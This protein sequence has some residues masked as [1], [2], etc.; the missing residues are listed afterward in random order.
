MI[1]AMHGS[2][3]NVAFA[4]KE[5]V[6]NDYKTV[7][8]PAAKRA[9]EQNDQVRLYYE[10]GR[11]VSSIGLGT[12]WEDFKIGVERLTR[13]ER[14]AVVTDIARIGHTIRPFS[15]LMPGDMR[16]CPAAQVV[17]AQQWTGAAAS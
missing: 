16:V 5:S 3:P 11:D 15:S 9:L 6:R 1:E 14:I 13:W 10:I 4:R 8:V 7:L 2:P 12:M 17:E